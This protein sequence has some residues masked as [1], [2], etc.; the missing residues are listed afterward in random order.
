[1]KV[2]IRDTLAP[3]FVE[4]ENLGQSGEVVADSNID[5]AFVSIEPAT[6]IEAS[7]AYVVVQDVGIA[8]PAGEQTITVSEQQPTGSA[9]EG[10]LW[11]VI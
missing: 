11:V 7:A 1:V 2:V 8:G 3:A 5:P 9:K 4:V 10:S 6:T